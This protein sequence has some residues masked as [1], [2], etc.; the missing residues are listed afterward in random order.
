MFRALEA[1]QPRRGCHLSRILQIGSLFAFLGALLSFLA[2]PLIVRCKASSSPEPNHQIAQVLPMAAQWTPQLPSFPSSSLPKSKMPSF[3]SYS[4]KTTSVSVRC[5]IPAR[6]V[7]PLT[8]QQYPW[9]AEVNGV[10]RI[11]LSAQGDLQRVLRSVR[12]S[13]LL[14]FVTN[15]LSVLSSRAPSS[16][17]SFIPRLSAKLPRIRLS[18][19]CPNP[20]MRLSKPSLPRLP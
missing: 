12:N 14:D 19:P 18:N 16:S 1:S 8:S 7:I 17:H 10:E 13:P 9:P 6:P 11:A 4:A 3:D 5:A 20:R 15:P 2:C